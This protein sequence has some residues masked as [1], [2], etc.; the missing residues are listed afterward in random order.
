MEKPSD[1]SGLIYIPFTDNV[2]DGK[3][4]LYKEM[5]SIGFRIDPSK[6]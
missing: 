3:T 6:L 4:Q 1:I 5:C 2:E